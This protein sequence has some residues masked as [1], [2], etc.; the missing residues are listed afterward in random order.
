MFIE[1]GCV[2]WFSTVCLS[3][4]GNLN[5]TIKLFLRNGIGLLYCIYWIFEFLLSRKVSATHALG[6][7]NWALSLILAA[8]DKCLASSGPKRQVIASTTP[9]TR[10][11]M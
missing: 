6:C 1:T 10:A 11:G 5:A 2:I 4:C 8:I 9:T 7:C 3:L